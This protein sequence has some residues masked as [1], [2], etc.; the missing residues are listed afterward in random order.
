MDATGVVVDTRDFPTTSAGI[1]R[2]LDWVGRRTA[3]DA[4]T[5]WVVEGAAS[6]GA[7]LTGTLTTAGCPD[8][9]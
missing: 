6:Y 5:L 1:R 3:G 9:C 8:G 2:A 7:L 4:D